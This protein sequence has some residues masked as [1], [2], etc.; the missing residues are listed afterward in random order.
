MTNY[1]A[2]KHARNPDR[3]RNYKNRQERTQ[4]KKTKRK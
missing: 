2:Q 1:K 3:Q 4:E